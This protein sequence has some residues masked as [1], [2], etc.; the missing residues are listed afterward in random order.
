MV[1]VGFL[2]NMGLEPVDRHPMLEYKKA[3]DTIILIV[4]IVFPGLKTL[5]LYII[6]SHNLFQHVYL[7][8]LWRQNGALHAP[9]VTLFPKKSDTKWKKAL[10]P[11]VIVR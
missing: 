9:Y 10:S 5:M 2:F 1:G 6:T 4:F 8:F 7:I 11:A 3:I